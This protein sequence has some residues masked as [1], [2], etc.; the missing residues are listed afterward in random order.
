MAT[1]RSSTLPHGTGHEVGFALITGLIF[2]VVMSVLGVTMMNVT[3]LETLMAGGSREANIAFQGAEAALRQAEAVIEGTASIAAFD[4]SPGM[5]SLADDEPDFFET[6]PADSLPYSNDPGCPAA[7][8][9]YPEVAEQ[10]RYVI[11]HVD[12]VVDSSTA[13]TSISIGGYGQ[14]MPASVAVFRITARGTSRD[15]SAETL[16]QSYYGKIY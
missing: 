6:D 7:N 4:G 12:D 9:C 16:V 8:S 10:P 11:K 15:S 13:G 14:A 2:L 3:R 1:Y 5:L